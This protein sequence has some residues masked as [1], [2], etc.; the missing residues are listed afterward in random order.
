MKTKSILVLVALFASGGLMAK[1]IE[2][3]VFK[4]ELNFNSSI[5]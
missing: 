1:N 2:K 5:I 4:E 3:E